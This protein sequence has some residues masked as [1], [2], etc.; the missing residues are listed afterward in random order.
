MSG[1]DLWRECQRRFGGDRDRALDET[2]RIADRLA[3]GHSD[4]KR[5]ELRRIKRALLGDAFSEDEYS[6][7]LGPEERA[8]L[9]LPFK[10]LIK[11]LK[12]VAR[13]LADFRPWDG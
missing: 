4:K 5:K 3:A 2:L 6:E 8:R 12:H 13:K 10:G 11:G 9:P 1:G 7:P